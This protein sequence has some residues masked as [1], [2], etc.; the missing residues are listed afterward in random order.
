MGTTGMSSRTI[1]L[2]IGVIGLILSGCGSDGKDGA[3]GPQGPAGE[4]AVPPTELHMSITSA[5]VNSAPVVNFTVTD[6][7]GKGYAALADTDLRFNIAK[8]TSG[9][10]GSESTWQNYIVRASGSGEMQGSQERV[11]TGYPFGTLTNHGDGTYT[12]TFATDITSPSANPCPS[13]CTDVDNNPLD[14]SYDSSL[15]HRIGI[16]Q[17]NRDLPLVN[18]TFDFVPAGGSPT[19]ERNIVKT[20][21]CNQCHRQLRLHGSRI[22]TKLCVT[23]HNPGSW[24]SDPANETVDFK[25]MIHRIHMGADLPVLPYAIGNHDYSTVEF[26]ADVRS[27]A[28]KNNANGGTINR[29]AC[30]KCHDPND[31]DTPQA[32]A[33]QTP[34]RAACSSCH[35]DVDFATGANHPGGIQTDDS[36]CTTCHKTGT[37]SPLPGSVMESHTLWDREYAQDCFQ[38]EIVSV[39]P[40]PAPP[41]STV[42]VT[43][44]V[45]NPNPGLA[46]GPDQRPGDPTCSTVATYGVL[47]DI[48][49]GGTT[50]GNSR[51]GIDIGWN[52]RDF[53]NADA[54][55][56]TGAFVPGLPI[57]INALDPANVTNN[58]DGTFSVTATVPVTATGTGRAAIE[59]HP[60]E[61]DPSTGART[62]RVPVKGVIKDFGITDAAG[63]VP[64]RQVVAIENCNNCH[65]WLSLHGSNRTEEP[66]LCVMCHNPNDTDINRRPKD[67]VTGLPNPDPAITL[68]GK[69]EES[70]DFKRMIHGIHAGAQVNYL[71]EPEHGFRSKGYVVFGY[72]GN[73]TDFSEVRF[74][75][76][77]LNLCD[78][79]HVDDTYTLE[80]RSGDG[81]ADWE[82][83]TQ[84]GILATTIDTAPNA[85]DQASFDAGLLDQADDLNISPT[86]AVCSAC[87]D[88]GPALSH[89]E[90][91]GAALFSDTQAMIDTNYEACEVCH[92]GGK[93]FDVEQVHGVE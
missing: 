46:L 76:G 1:F 22:E 83:P 27:A 69:K 88:D 49:L 24:V 66:Q 60:A 58:G 25:I 9:N 18:A 63:G 67:A 38:Y 39:T 33:Y 59:G 4:S 26:P 43:F 47:G 75:E 73:P 11:R 92:G 45:T 61:I 8:L 40:D 5:S 53:N 77:V 57:Q 12:Y 32:I 68:D 15:T 17:G 72:S 86:A 56:A 84:D 79:C 71:G 64:R 23:C 14:I 78:T 21:T 80:D 34:K 7:D 81:G 19:L 65:T 62:V 55:T 3:T 85:V 44:K 29:V 89:M 52:T 74:P 13:P 35:N 90:A 2:A 70:I 93:D 51:L 37:L 50:D 30:T 48:A 54:D 20:E 41:G 91:T 42:T 28:G 6:Q 82:Q 31:T 36:G 16:Q 10:L 87:H